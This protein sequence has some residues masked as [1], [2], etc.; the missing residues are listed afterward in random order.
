MRAPTAQAAEILA[1]GCVSAHLRAVGYSWVRIGFSL[2]LNS[3]TVRRLAAT[4][5]AYDA[6]LHERDF[7]RDAAS[8]ASGNTPE[9][10]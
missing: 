8:A 10:S 3:M 1:H 4:W 2:G 6:L 9:E 5:L 7:R